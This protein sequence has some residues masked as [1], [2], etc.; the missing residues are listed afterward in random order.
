[1]IN[2]K[3]PFGGLS[4]WFFCT[5]LVCLTCVGCTT[6]QKEPEYRSMYD[7]PIGGKSP[8]QEEKS[9]FAWFKPKEPPVPR[10]PREW[11]AQEQILP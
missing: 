1:M 6:P 4:R 9:L 3:R 10:T 11:M 2:Q 8:E 7:Y 5:V